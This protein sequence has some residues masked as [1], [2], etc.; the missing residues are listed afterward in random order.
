[1]TERQQTLLKHLVEAHIESAGPISSS[2]LVDRSDLGVSSATIRNDLVALE[3]RGY[4]TS[5]HTS[6]GRIPTEKGYRFYIEWFV[7]PD[8]KVATERQA[9]KRRGQ[10]ED[11]A[12]RVRRL[13]KA[14]SELTGQ[15]VVLSES[16]EQSYATGISRLLAMP[17]FHDRARV[18]RLAEMMDT[19]D[20]WLQ[21]FYDEMP[22]EVRVLLGDESPFGEHMTSMAISYKTP[23]QSQ[24]MIT[25]IG[26][27]RMN[28][29][30]NMALL[31]EVKRLLGDT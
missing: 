13:A 11:R 28:Y 3:E 19:R 23:S 2:V 26:P 27:M 24:G 4:I 12:L 1:M 18:L 5:P 31:R 9:L 20:R 29:E 16:P 17:E 10:A 7:K 14:L 30:Y 8:K 21:R 6:A 25:L 22:Q 15:A